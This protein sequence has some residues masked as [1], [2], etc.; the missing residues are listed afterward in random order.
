MVLFLCVCCG[1]PA[2]FADEPKQ[3][4]ASFADPTAE[5]PKDGSVQWDGEVYIAPFARVV[6]S[7]GTRVQ[8]GARSNVQDNAVLDASRND[9]VL[10]EGAIIA[11]GAMIKSSRPAAVAAETGRPGYGN[12]GIDALERYMAAHPSAYKWGALPAFVGFNAVVDG[13]NVSDGSMVMHMAMV[14]PGI[15]IKSGIKVLAGKRVRTQIE[16]DD[17]ARGKVVYLSEKDVE[18]MNGVVEVNTA[19]AAGYSQLA[20]EQISFV[21]GIGYNP[22]LVPGNEQ[23]ELPTVG[24]VKTRQPDTGTYRYRIIGNVTIGDT[25]GIRDRVSLRADEGPVFRIGAANRFLGAN[26]FHALQHTDISAGDRVILEPN[27]IVH[28]GAGEHLKEGRRTEIGDGTVI[29]AGS[30]VFASRLG[31]NVRVG[32]NSLVMDSVIPDGTVIP[33]GEVW[34]GGRKLYKVE[35]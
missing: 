2:V 25:H 18:F 17:P 22:G 19:L 34:S 1:M 3:Q 32:A 8:L 6:T 9:I 7:A 27:A 14:G 4:S 20:R 23:R 12:P 29:G 35:W 13:A 10:G 11:H 24:G 15:T 30:V 31:S 16:A 28:G 5:L 26:T 21:R 33:P